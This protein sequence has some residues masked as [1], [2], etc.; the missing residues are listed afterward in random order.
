MLA[1]QTLGRRR[2]RRPND[3]ADDDDDDK[4]DAIEM[5]TTRVHKVFLFTLIINSASFSSSSLFSFSSSSFPPS[6]R[7]PRP[8]SI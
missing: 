8:E 7:L 3:N 1:P 4:Q 2:R 6:S 5:D